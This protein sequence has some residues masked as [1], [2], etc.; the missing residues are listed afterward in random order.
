MPPKKEALT[1]AERAKR[2][3]D[4]AREAETDNDPKSFERPFEKVIRAPQR[5]A[6]PVPQE[7]ALGP[8]QDSNPRFR[9]WRPAS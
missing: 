2:I 8:R 9:G 1:D 3:R 5:P 6:K 7:I 4:L